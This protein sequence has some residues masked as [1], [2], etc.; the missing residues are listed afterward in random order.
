MPICAACGKDFPEG[1]RFCN[2]CGRNVE[3]GSMGAAT[4]VP[5]PPPPYA[6][7][8]P[9]Y[10]M[11]APVYYGPRKSLALSLVLTI[12]FGPLG[13]LYSTVEGALI[14]CVVTFFAMFTGIGLLI[15]WPVC[16]VWGAMAVENY[17]ARMMYW[18][19]AR[20]GYPVL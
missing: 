10:G 16:V 17:N 5:P 13:M 2:H 19:G 15:A 12:F 14:M 3:S 4:P 9:A 6:F 8:T 1:A 18:S 20:V 11:G 7:Q